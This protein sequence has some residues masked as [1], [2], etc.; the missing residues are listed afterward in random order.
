MAF[1]AGAV[2]SKLTLDRSKFSASIRAVQKQT[3]TLGGR[4]T[5][6]AR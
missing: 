2:V 4:K 1:Q 5:G 6:A 3:R